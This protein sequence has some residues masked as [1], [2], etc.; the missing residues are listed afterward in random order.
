ML[1]GAGL[2]GLGVAAW[3]RPDARLFRALNVD[4][5]Y[6]PGETASRGARLFGWTREKARTRQEIT[7][8][9]I[10]PV[11][12]AFWMFLGGVLLVEGVQCNRDYA[13]VHGNAPSSTPR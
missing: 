1:L 7:L 6:P 8:K 9:A 13:R 10:V 3:L 4:R 2:V 5:W 11:V 12:G